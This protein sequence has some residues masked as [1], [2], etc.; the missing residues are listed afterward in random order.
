MRYT[1][2]QVVSYMDETYAAVYVVAKAESVNVTF[3]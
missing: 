1:F 2:W 3:M